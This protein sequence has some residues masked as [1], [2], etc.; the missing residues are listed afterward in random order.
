MSFHSHNRYRQKISFNWLIPGPD[1]MLLVDT[2]AEVRAKGGQ[3]GVNAFVDE[4]RKRGYLEC[5]DA[6]AERLK[7]HEYVSR[8]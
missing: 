8:P 6:D 4:W 5:T 2:I 1:W 3:E 7:R